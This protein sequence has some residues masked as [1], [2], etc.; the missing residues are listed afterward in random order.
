MQGWERKNNDDEIYLCDFCETKVT[1][2]TRWIFRRIDLE[3]RICRECGKP[4]FM[5]SNTLPELVD[6]QKEPNE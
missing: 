1:S 2:K 4:T 3:V 5:E 6:K